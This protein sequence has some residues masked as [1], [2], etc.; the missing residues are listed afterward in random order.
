MVKFSRLP[1]LALG[2]IALLGAM[3]GG[4][5]RLGWNVHVSDSFLVI[6][7]HGHLMVAG[8]LG[9]LI[10]LEQAVALGHKWGF[11]APL[12]TG[13]GAIAVAVGV[14][15]ISHIIPLTLITIGSAILLI[16]TF[17]VYRQKPALYTEIMMIGA[18]SLVVGNSLL[19][20]K[21][22]IHK[23]IVWWMVFP[24]LTI[25]GE[26][27]ELARFGP[28][29]KTANFILYTGLII[30]I[31]GMPLTILPMQEIGNIL[32]GIAFLIFTFWLFC[33]DIAR[34]TVKQSGLTRFTAVSLLLGYIWLGAGGVISIYLGITGPMAQGNLYDLFIHAVFLGFTFSMIFG[35]APIIFPA[36]LNI[37]ISYHPRFYIHLL[38]LHISLF[39][40][41]LGDIVPWYEGRL[42]GGLFNVI[43]I[44]FFLINTI[45]SIRKTTSN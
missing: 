32:T 11:L 18:F 13:I 27:L 14:T 37:T 25:L 16:I 38:L 31:A 3:W 39:I 22:P 20:N 9:T 19:L 44:L 36:I 21:W 5:G 2:I 43:A 42:W 45:T 34:Q 28:L 33:F 1:F 4:L 7:N 26:R 24:V 30:L 12:F 23:L 15:S 41:I 6:P 35:H 17:T 10:A 8:F 40:R 29:P